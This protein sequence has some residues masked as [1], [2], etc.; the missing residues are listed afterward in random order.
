MFLLVHVLGQE[1]WVLLSVL[2]GAEMLVAFKD[3]GSKSL[4]EEN[5]HESVNS[6]LSIFK[7]N[8]LTYILRWFRL[9]GAFILA[10][11]MKPVA[12]YCAISEFGTWT[13]AAA[14]LL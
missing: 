2:A 6:N 10:K 11:L 8:C 14:I 12:M 9:T 3:L 4:P 13:E 7:N 5:D 1:H